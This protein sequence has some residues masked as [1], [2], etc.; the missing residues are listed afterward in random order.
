[1]SILVQDGA[2]SAD[3]KNVMVTVRAAMTD[4]VENAHMPVNVALS[5]DPSFTAYLVFHETSIAASG[6]IRLADGRLEWKRT[7]PW[8]L[9][10]GIGSCSTGTHTVYARFYVNVPAPAPD[11]D[12]T[13]PGGAPVCKQRP[14]CLSATPACS[15]SV[16]AGGWCP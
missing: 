15:L 14:A 1:L 13:G 6:A 9:C 10:F 7:F 3:A 16:P 8:D 11:I 2:V 5:N 12:I 4:A